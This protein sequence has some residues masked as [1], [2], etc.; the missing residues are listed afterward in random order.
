MKTIAIKKYYFKKFFMK[1]ISILT[2]IFIFTTQFCHG[3][4]DDSATEV[5]Q[6][7]VQ[8]DIFHKPKTQPEKAL[9]LVFDGNHKTTEALRESINDAEKEAVNRN[10]GGKY[11]DGELCGLDYDVLTCSQDPPDSE[12]RLYRTIREKP[13]EAVIEVKAYNHD[14]PEYPMWK[15][16][17]IKGE[18]WLDGI[19]CSADDKFNF[20]ENDGS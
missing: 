19:Y 7:S 9:H 16:V 11:I 4:N 6:G 14:Q 8:S 2:L 20:L 1:I 17:K 3:H 5:T 10:C 18:W 15:M 12:N 13:I